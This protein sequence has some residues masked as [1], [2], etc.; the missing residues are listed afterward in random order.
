MPYLSTYPASKAAL[1]FFTDALSDEFKK[2]NVKVQVGLFF[3]SSWLLQCLVPLLVA[4]KAA[5]YEAS[6][7]NNLFVVTTENFAR[8]AVR[9]IGRWALVTGCIQHD[10]QVVIFLNV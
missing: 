3:L 9:L 10:I 4:T 5:S 6:E 7:A 8:Q 2:T 1:A